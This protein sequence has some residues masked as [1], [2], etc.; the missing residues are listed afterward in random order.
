VRIGDAAAPGDPKPTN[1]H[2]QWARGKAFDELVKDYYGT[3]T[4][5]FDRAFAEEVLRLNTGNRRLNKRKLQ[6]LVDQMRSGEFENTGE[7]VIISKEGVINNG[8]HR[9]HAVVEADAV[10]DMDVRFGIPRRVFSKT[11]TGAPRTGADVLSIKGVQ[12][13]SQ[14]SSTVRLLIL[15]S[16]GLPES[17]RTFVSN[18]EVARAFDSWTDIEEVVAKLGEHAIPK[19]VRSTPL[20]ATAFLA[21]RTPQRAKLDKWLDAVATGLDVSK[22]NPAYQLRERLMRGIEAPIGT[23]EGQLERF[24]LMIKSWNLWSKGDTVTMREFRWVQSGRNAEEFPKVSGA[25]L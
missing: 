7:P 21:S 12:A 14:V 2:A 24:A 19:A 17:I 20:L 10:V 1:A 22:D 11:D 9:L 5:M 18:D 23:R 16:R 8:Q 13:G 3:K 15:Y 25:R 4:L 6:Q